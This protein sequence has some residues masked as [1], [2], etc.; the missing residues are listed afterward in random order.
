M[1]KEEFEE[2]LFV[3]EEYGFEEDNKLTKDAI[4]LKKDVLKYV[5]SLPV[6]DFVKSQFVRE[7][8][9]SKEVK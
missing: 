6:P 1:K 4:Q 2:L 8:Q 5:E 9:S 7:K 3:Y